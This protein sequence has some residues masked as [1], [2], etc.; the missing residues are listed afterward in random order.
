MIIFGH[1]RSRYQGPLT[2][3]QVDKHKAMGSRFFWVRFSQGTSYRDPE[4]VAATRLLQANGFPVG[5]Y[6]FTT[7]DNALSQYN[8]FVKCM[9]DIQFDLP[10]AMDVE[11]YSSMSEL[12]NIRRRG[13]GIEEE[14]VKIITDLRY[15]KPPLRA[16]FAAPLRYSIPTAA[17]VDSLGLKLTTWMQ[18]QS[19]LVALANLYPAYAFPAIYTN[20]SSGNA[21]FTKKYAV[22]ADRYN[23]W[24]ANWGVQSPN[25]PAIWKGKPYLVWQDKVEDGAPYGIVGQLDHDVWGTAVPFPGDTPV[26]PVDHVFTV[27]VTYDGI[28]HKF[29]EVK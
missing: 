29:T 17:I 27:T 20:V 7:T 22:M 23:L 18:G 28:A 6:H 19:K 16:R 21:V 11:Y 12:R 9:G 4:A 10:P 5:P 24:A 15:D 14:E 3:A 8:W 13:M 25:L 2:Q 26:P 1:D